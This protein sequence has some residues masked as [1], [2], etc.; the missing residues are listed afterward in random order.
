MDLGR[1]LKVSEYY[2]SSV[3]SLKAA[4]EILQLAAAAVYISKYHKTPRNYSE[5]QNGL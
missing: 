3:G 2:F 5:K 4:P 1:N